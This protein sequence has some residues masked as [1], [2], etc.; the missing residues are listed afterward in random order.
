MKT[1]KQIVTA[2]LQTLI[3]HPHHDE[4]Q[5]SAFFDRSYQ[6]TVDGKQL[7]YA[8]FLNHM[9]AIKQHTKRMDMSIETIVAEDNRV[10]THHYVDVENTQGEGSQFEVFACFTLAAGKIVRCQELTRMVQGAPS[11][12]GLGSRG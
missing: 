6:Q 2:A 4:Q 8:G 3:A 5:I 11:E 9:A 7:D 12:A 1:P 10:F